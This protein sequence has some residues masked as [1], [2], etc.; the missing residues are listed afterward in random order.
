MNEDEYYQSYADESGQD[1]SSDEFSLTSILNEYSEPRVYMDEY[2]EY[3]SRM[4]RDTLAEHIA[5]AD[6][7][8]TPVDSEID[9][10]AEKYFYEHDTRRSLG[11]SELFG[12]E[13]PAE[14]F[15]DESK[16]PSV[17][18]E[19]EEYEDYGQYEDYETYDDYAEADAE[20]FGKDSEKYAEEYPEAEEATARYAF[21]SYS[22]GFEPTGK[23][24]FDPEHGGKMSY[25][26]IAREYGRDFRGSGK[27]FVYGD[28]ESHTGKYAAAEP[29]EE[30]AYEP[31]PYGGTDA[32]GYYEEDG[33]E[34]ED[35]SDFYEYE[36]S[37]YDYEEP[38][39]ESGYSA[40]AEPEQ[41]DDDDVKIYEDVKR[42]EPVIDDDVKI[43]GAPAVNVSYGNRR[44][45]PNDFRGDVGAEAEGD[46]DVKPYIPRER[47]EKDFE[48]LKAE[49][50]AERK[51]K[52]RRESRMAGINSLLAMLRLKFRKSRID[53]GKLGSKLDEEED[54][55]PEA[56]PRD[57][58][59][60]YGSQIRS[61]RSRARL[62][63]ALTAI[64]SW[65][66]LGLPVFGALRTDLKTASIVLLIIELA[67]LMVGLDVFTAGITAIFRGRPGIWSLLSLTLIVTA[68]DAAVT[69]SAGVKGDGLPYCALG[70]LCMSAALYSS[71][72]QT[73]ALR[74]SAKAL[75]LIETPYTV[76][77]EADVIEGGRSVVKSQ[78]ITDGFIKTAEA[79]SF[80]EELYTKL[81]FPIII[82]A[83][84]LAGVV[85]MANKNIEGYIH[86]LSGILTAG[87]PI[88]VFMTFPISYARLSRVLFHQGAAV[89]GWEG[90]RD[91]GR[92]RHMI[93]TDSDI[94]PP[95][96]VSIEAVRILDGMWPESIISAAGS[97]ICASGSGLAPAFMDLMKKNNCERQEVEDF[98]CHEGGGLT[99][100][101]NGMEVICGSASFMNLMSIRIPRRMSLDNCIYLAINRTI[102]GVFTIDYRPMPLVKAALSEI[103]NV[104]RQPYFAIRDFLVTPLMIRNKF[105]ISTDGFEFPT[106]E[107]RYE[108]S[109]IEPG[110]DSQVSAVL[111]REGLGSFVLLTERVRKLYMISFV[112][113]GFA[114]VIG[115]L[116][117]LLLTYYPIVGAFASADVRSVLFYMLLSL[118]P[119]LVLNIVF[120]N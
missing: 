37:G 12:Y 9:K 44:Y 76:T 86:Y 107:R 54:L 18:D 34:L 110:Q 48:R 112:F 62:S 89:A 3:V 101:I 56:S 80:M 14:Y 29:A 88:V 31:E 55:G 13:N 23:C 40:K 119:G 50:K 82:F 32:E 35:S 36:R 27:K 42:Y 102:M 73:R 95:S 114:L 117:M 71:L 99:A 4:I 61:L 79:P 87:L 33:E 8:N 63:A 66:S 77:T 111:T 74:Y 67:V 115:F 41:F 104:K 5:E 70:C 69:A 94:F 17:F 2:D 7:V 43:Y 105:K 38:F 1:F 72:Q 97:I 106:F 47:V 51:K 30:R 46:E 45:D 6:A 58:S 52:A 39:E 90:V 109:S 25:E 83:A 20:I 15:A 64:A 53:G 120:M 98:Y 28:S 91:I 65:I 103:M 24:N 60:Y 19:R 22:A 10:A 75:E 113:L 68:L 96:A 78:I 108:I 92:S 81:V 57:A 16:A 100:R 49:Q 26:E 21:P 118:V 84:L 93:V 116:G 11:E 85:S 59:R